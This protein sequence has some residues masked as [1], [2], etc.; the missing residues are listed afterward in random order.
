VLSCFVPPASQVLSRA[1]RRFTLE[2]AN[3]MGSNIKATLAVVVVIFP[4]HEN[5]SFVSRILAERAE[6]RQLRACWFFRVR[7]VK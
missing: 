3:P 5:K 7:D 4:R 1:A 6:C 2:V